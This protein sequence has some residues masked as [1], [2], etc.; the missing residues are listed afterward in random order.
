[1]DPL[2]AGRSVPELGVE[3]F[4]AIARASLGS[5][6]QRWYWSARLRIG[7]D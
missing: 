1:M 2:K 5:A 3:E 6:R 7:V 4:A